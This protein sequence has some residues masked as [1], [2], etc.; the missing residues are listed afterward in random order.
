MGNCSEVLTPVAFRPFLLDVHDLY[1]LL[2]Q[3]FPFCFL[4]FCSCNALEHCATICMFGFCYGTSWVMDRIGFPVSCLAPD[5]LSAAAADIFCLC[6]CSPM[7]MGSGWPIP[8]LGSLARFAYEW[9]G[10]GQISPNE[11]TLQKY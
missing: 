11:W 7:L 4:S 9:W 8:G 6:P 2:V 1:W 10:H 5:P 3:W